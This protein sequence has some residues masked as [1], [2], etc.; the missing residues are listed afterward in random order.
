MLNSPSA[1]P[2]QK[3][4]R[5]AGREYSND[6]TTISLVYYDTLVPVHEIPFGPPCTLQSSLQMIL[7][8]ITAKVTRS[9]L[10]NRITLTVL[11]QSEKLNFKYAEY[12]LLSHSLYHIILTY[13]RS[14][15]SITQMSGYEKHTPRLMYYS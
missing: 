5:T 9:F 4:N 7:C 14:H 1:L 8:F 2:S 10:F 15:V 3:C 11:A 12:C 6:K 13:R